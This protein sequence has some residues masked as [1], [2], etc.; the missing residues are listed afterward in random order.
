M[1]CFL[2]LKLDSKSQLN[3]DKLYAL[4]FKFC[5]QN[6]NNNNNKK[7]IEITFACCKGKQDGRPIGENFE[8]A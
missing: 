7:D 3:Y 2:S 6:Y 4:A 8:F 5:I 1:G